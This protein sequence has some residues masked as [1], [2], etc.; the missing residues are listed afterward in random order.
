MRTLL[1]SPRVVSIDVSIRRVASCRNSSIVAI[2]LLL[3]RRR[4]DRADALAGDDAEDVPAASSKT[5]IGRPLSMQ[6]ES[7]VV[8][9]TRRPRSIA[10]RWVS[11][12]RNVAPRVELR[13]A[14]VD[15]L[16]AVLRHQDRLGADLERPQRGG[17]VGR[18][19]RVAR[20]GGEDHDA[21]LLEMAHRAP[22]DVRLGD[23]RDRDRRLHPR[24]G[25]EALERV[26]QR[27]RVQERREHAGVVRRS[28]GPSRPPRPP[29]RGRSCRRRRR[30]RAPCPRPAR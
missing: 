8:S 10:S 17:R 27:E 6:S 7:A 11:S 21:A 9:I 28:H 30:S 25:A 26:L 1:N 14:V 2:S 13:I 23:L 15:A 4:D 18:E 5:W 24:V 19:E 12:G 29:C 22:A 20:A 16:H 3:R